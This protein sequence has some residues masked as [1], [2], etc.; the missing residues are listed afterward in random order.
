MAETNGAVE[1]VKIATTRL[2]NIENVFHSA[3]E[4]AERLSNCHIELKDIAQEISHD[5]ENVDFDPNRL[6][7]LNQRLDY[8]YSL[9]QKFHVNSIA[10]LLA[11]RD[12]LKSKLENIDNSDDTISE[13]QHKVDTLCNEC[14]S[15]SIK[16]TKLRTDSAKKVEKEMSDRLIPLGIPNVRFQ[17][18]LTNKELAE[19]G[20][21]KISF[22]F[23]ANKSTPLQPVSQVASGGEI[24]R[25]MLSLKAMISGVVKLPTIIFDEID[26]GVSGR[27][28]EM[29]AQIMQEMGNN[30]RQ[31]ISITHLPQIAAFGS[32]HYKVEKEET[33]EGTI[34]TMRMLNNRERINEIAQMLSG[35]NIT[36][37]AI[38]NAKALLKL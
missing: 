24:A 33:A 4:L 35:S 8:I 22:L 13:I 38:S 3:K 28:A 25:V 19:D 23:S 27:V 34:S 2:Q 31:V 5:V 6:N 16:L 9:E 30:E 32:T 7:D 37:E 15:K 14:K 18:E 10:E 20:A 26:T 21:D 17:I 12:D 11:I 36:E 1:Q 29:M